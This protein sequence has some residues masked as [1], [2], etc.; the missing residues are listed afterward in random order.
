MPVSILA[1]YEDEVAAVGQDKYRGNSESVSRPWDF[2]PSEL[3]CHPRGSRY[4]V[5]RLECC[6]LLRKRRPLA[7]T[8]NCFIPSVRNTSD[9]IGR[10]RTVAVS[11]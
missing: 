4:W 3:L 11:R 8:S 7:V 1:S 2:R 10:R 9:E 5:S 6:M